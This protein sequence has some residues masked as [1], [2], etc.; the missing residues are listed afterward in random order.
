[1]KF[2]FNKINEASDRKFR[3]GIQTRKEYKIDTDSL[4][5][6]IKT[7][8][9][10]K[11]REK[12]KQK[13]EYLDEKDIEFYQEYKDN[14]KYIKDLN[15]NNTGMSFKIF[16]LLSGPGERIFKI[17][18]NTI[19]EFDHIF[20]NTKVY[21]D[22]D[23][24]LQLKFKF[25]I[26]SFNAVT[27]PKISFE[28]FK[29]IVNDDYVEIKKILNKVENIVDSVLNTHFDTEALKTKISNSIKLYN[30][31]KEITNESTDI[32]SKLASKKNGKEAYKEYLKLQ[33]EIRNYTGKFLDLLG[34]DNN[35]SKVLLKTQMDLGTALSTELETIQDKPKTTNNA[36]NTIT[37]PVVNAQK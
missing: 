17:I 31:K 3:P 13:Q 1:M 21:N 34:A 8:L 5:T 22:N 33:E 16:N 12:V 11:Q 29:T 25:E 24:I 7:R 19:P 30:E 27:N 36:P 23:T 6:P 10:D 37:P 14:F 2:R 9:E 32:E 18:K 35:I 4:N 15:Y 20:S 28:E 26:N